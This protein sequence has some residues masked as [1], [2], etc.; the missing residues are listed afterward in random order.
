MIGDTSHN[1][2]CVTQFKEI[3]LQI[4]EI[5]SSMSIIIKIKIL[6][7]RKFLIIVFCFSSEAMPESREES[8]ELGWESENEQKKEVPRTRT[9]KTYRVER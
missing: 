5:I 9:T 6:S 8:R 4:L 7:W 2:E 1:I 3:I